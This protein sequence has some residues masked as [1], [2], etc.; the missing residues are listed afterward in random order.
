MSIPLFRQMQNDHGRVDRLKT[1]R[2]AVTPLLAGNYLSNFTDH[3]V[4]HSDQLCEIVDKLTVSLEPQKKLNEEEAY[5]LYA[6]CYLHDAGMQH[7]RA[8][9][10]Q[11]VSRVLKGEPYSGQ[12]W[13]ELEEETRKNIIREHHHRI[14]SE[15]V[16]NAVR[17]GNPEI[18]IAL[19]ESDKPGVIAALCL[20]HCLASDSVEYQDTTAD[21]GGLRV[22]LLAALLRLADILDESHRRVELTLEQIRELPLESRLHWWRHSYISYVSIEARNIAVWF[23]FPPGRRS[24]YKE[25]IEP[26]Q[27]P[28]IE[29]EFGRHSKVLGDN[30]LAWHILA[31]DTREAQSTSQVMDDE[32]ERY[33]VEKT[34]AHQREKLRQQH[35]TAVAQLRVAR[36]TIIREFKALQDTTDPQDVLIGKAQKLAE[37]LFAIGG[38]RDAWIMLQSEFS[39]LKSRISEETM[40]NVALRLGE[41]MVEDNA[42]DTA[43]RHLREYYPHFLKLTPGSINKLRFLNAWAF[44]LRDSC[45]Y[46]EAACAFDEIA[47]T[48]TQTPEREN[49]LAEI[50]EMHLLQGNLGLIVCS[51]EDM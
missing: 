36:P 26:L 18:G 44:A 45:A 3:S 32:L 4:S 22:G 49:A 9:N 7:Q 35:L 14:S 24:Q 31:Q 23:D 15:L 43:L 17:N 11:V 1:I 13:E 39:R 33:A 30:G 8:G 50:A 47:Q 19:S 41:M 25:L 34:V 38:R 29:A 2:N 21:Q 5:V 51:E 46:Q 16:R 10:T 40:L 37:H 27:M 12:K 48:T 28:L 6:A 20:A 42:A